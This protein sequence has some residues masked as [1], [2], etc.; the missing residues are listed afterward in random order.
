MKLREN[1][2]TVC[3]GCD[4]TGEYE[5]AIG[6]FENSVTYKLTQCDCENGKE[7]DWEKVEAEINNTKQKIEINQMSVSN[8]NQFMREAMRNKDESKAIIALKLLIDKESEIEELELY[9]AELEVIE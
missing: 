4:G 6:G 7:L 8:Y 1:F 2:L 3:G 5:E 9:L